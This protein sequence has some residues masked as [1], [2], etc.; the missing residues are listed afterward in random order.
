MSAASELQSAVVAALGSAPGI[1]GIVAGVFDGPPARADFPY[2]VI[3]DGLMV[4][5]STKTER[6]REHRLAITAWD[7]AGRAA[8]LHALIGAVEA[9]LDALPAALPT[10]RIVSRQVQRSQILRARSGP[11]AGVVDYR[12]R[13]LEDQGD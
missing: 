2:L 13:T 9:T 10:N 1:G 12:F 7:E 11:W 6:G 5:W 4:D 8:R 3:G